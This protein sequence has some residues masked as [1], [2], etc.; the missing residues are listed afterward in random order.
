MLVG[1]VFI[2][3]LGCKSDDSATVACPTAHV[4]CFYHVF[5]VRKVVGSCF[6]ERTWEGEGKVWYQSFS[7][8]GGVCYPGVC[9]GGLMSG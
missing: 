3:S 8:R 1:S 9:F 6:S 5:T 7:E 4:C 2:G